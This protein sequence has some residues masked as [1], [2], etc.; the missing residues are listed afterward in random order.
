MA[1]LMF[2]LVWGFLGIFLIWFSI[3]GHAWAEAAR[4]VWRSGRKPSSLS[5]PRLGLFVMGLTWLLGSL[6]IG[7]L[8]Y[9]DPLEHHPTAFLCVILGASFGPLVLGSLIGSFFRNRS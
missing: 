9:F 8:S 5:E 6:A 4:E 2:G 3:S 1:A 7:G